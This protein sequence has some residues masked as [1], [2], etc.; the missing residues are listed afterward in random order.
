MNVRATGS[1]LHTPHRVLISHTSLRRRAISRILEVLKRRFR[2]RWQNVDVELGGMAGRYGI[3]L[4]ATIRFLRGGKFDSVRTGPGAGVSSRRCRVLI[5][6]FGASGKLE[7][8][9]TILDHRHRRGRGGTAVTLPRRGPMSEDVIARMGLRER[10]GI[11]NRVSLGGIKGHGPT[12]TRPST[13]PRPGIR[14]I[15][16]TGRRPSTGSRPRVQRAMER[17]IR[18]RPGGSIINARRSK[19]FHLGP[20]TRTTP[21]LGMGKRVSL[22]TLGRSAHPGGGAGRRGHHRHRRG[23]H[24]NTTNA[25]RTNNGGGHMHVNGRHMSIGTITKRRGGN[26]NNG[27]HEGSGTSGGTTERSKN[28]GR[29]GGGGHRTP[30]LGGRISSRSMTGRMERALTHLA[31]GDGTK[32]NTGCHGRGHR[33][34]H[35]SVRRRLR[36]ETTSDVILG[37]ARFIATGRLTIVVSI[38]IAR[39]VDAYVDVNVVISVGRHLS[40][41]AVGLITRRFNFGARCIDTRISRTIARRRSSSRSLIPHT[42]VIAIVKRMSRNGASLL[43]CIHGAGIVTN[44]TNNVARRV[45]TCGIALRSNHRVA[46]LSAPNRRT[47]ATVHT[48]NTRIASVTVVVVTT[49]SSVVPR[50]G[51]TVGRTVTTN[52]PVIFTVGGISGPATGPRGVGRN[53]T[54]VAFLIRS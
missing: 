3:K 48:H 20:T 17:A 45:N 43:S 16:R 44:R 7:S 8:S 38:P 29:G 33:G 25:A 35:T 11:M 12:V 9:T 4:R 2:R 13:S 22:S 37:L 21:R 46:F 24:R 40:T 32:G 30:I 47:F 52:I 50:A 6:R 1:M 51:R 28:N 42:P 10:P 53:L 41:R 15:P 34:T 27:G 23:N 14:A 5:T 39:I 31:N 18:P 49:S 19:I 26:K 54:T 36:R